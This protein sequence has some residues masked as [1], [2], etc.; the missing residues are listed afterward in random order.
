MVTAIIREQV[1][2]PL[3]RSELEAALADLGAG[4][5]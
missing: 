1:D 5:G 2:K 3:N 4:A